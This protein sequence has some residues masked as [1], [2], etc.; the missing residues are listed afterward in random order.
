[1]ILRVAFLRWPTR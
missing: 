1:M